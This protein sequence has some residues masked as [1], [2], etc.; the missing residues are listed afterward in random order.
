MSLGG[1]PCPVTFGSTGRGATAAFCSDIASPRTSPESRS[2]RRLPCPGGLAAGSGLAL[3]LWHG[4]VRPAPH[5]PVAEVP[6]HNV[7]TGASK[8]HV[9]LT[10]QA[11]ST[12]PACP[13]SAPD[14]VLNANAGARARAISI[15]EY[16]R[17]CGTEAEFVTTRPE[18]GIV[19]VGPE[20]GR[21]R[22]RSTHETARA[23]R[24]RCAAQTRV[25]LSDEVC[26]VWVTDSALVAGKDTDDHEDHQDRWGERS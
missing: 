13:A 2:H 10:R 5:G 21:S 8:I 1:A 7:R 17:G 14:A 12:R 6:A 16:R 24:N 11:S 18:A 19:D 26:V 20:S 22:R 15:D 9:L 25:G 4:V 3:G 23:V